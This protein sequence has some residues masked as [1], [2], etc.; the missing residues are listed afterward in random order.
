MDQT[1]IKRHLLL[2]CKVFIQQR[3]DLAEKMMQEAQES[4]NN[5]SKS[6]AGDKYET[7][8]AMMHLEQEKYARQ[9]ADAI[10]VASILNKINTEKIG[11]KVKLGSVV[12]TSAGNYF[13]AISAGRISLDCKKYFAISPQAPLARLFFDR[14]AGEYV[15]FNEKK[16]FI[17]AVF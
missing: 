15:L 1:E 11:D 14:R 8:R 9:L 2:Q 17:E 3:I 13:I 16:L 4:A 12:I 5:E 7:G 6:S 10:Q